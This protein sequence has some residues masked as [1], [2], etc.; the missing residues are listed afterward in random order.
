MSVNIANDG[1][2]SAISFVCIAPL[3]P[4]HVIFALLSVSFFYIR[5][6]IIWWIKIILSLLHSVR[7]Q[8]EFTTNAAND[9]V[10]SLEC[11]DKVL[12]YTHWANLVMATA[13]GS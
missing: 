10:S 3:R 7:K 11:V 8:C 6:T 2:Y 9:C 5:A 4:S 1:L 12:N 13:L